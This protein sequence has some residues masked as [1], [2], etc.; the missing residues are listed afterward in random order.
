MR[1][2]LLYAFTLLSFSLSAQVVLEKDIN[3][4][5][6]GSWP[7]AFAEYDGYL[8]FKADDGTH[9]EELHR[10]HLATGAEELVANVRPNEDGAGISRVLAFDGKIYF[11]ARDGIG[12]RPYLYVYNPADNT[13][14]RLSD[15]NNDQV[16]DPAN[17]F[18][19]DGVLYFASEFIDPSIGVEFGSYDPATNLI[20]RLAD[21]QEGDGDSYPNF[22]NEVDGKIY[23]IANDGVSTSRLWRYDPA[24]GMTE[25]MAYETPGGV[26]PGNM[27]ILFAFNDQLFFRGTVTGQGTELWI[28]D[29]ATNSLVDF[30]EVYPGAGSSAPSGFT[31]FDER[32]FFGA[33]TVGGGRELRVYDPMTNEVTMV[34]DIHPDDD[35][36]PGDMF[37]LDGKLYFTANIDDV[38]RRLFSYDPVTDMVEEEVSQP[39]GDDS[40]FLSAL[41]AADGRIFLTGKNP[42]TA[43]ELYSY[44]PGNTEVELE[45]DINQNTI[46]SSPFEF[47]EYNGRLYFGA[48]EVNSGREIWVYDPATGNT[49]ILSDAEG[50]MNPGGFTVLG[51]RLY[52]E[53]VH[54]TEGYGLLYYDD[55]TGNITATSFLTPTTI[56]H[57]SELTAYDGK[58]YLNAD[59][60]DYGTELFVY[61]PDTDMLEL[62]AEINVNGDGRPEWLYVFN[63]ILYFEADDGN[64]GTE[65]WQ[66][67]AS[68]G[69]VSQIAD[70]NAGPEGS[71]PEWLVGY[72][73]ELYFSAFEPDESNELYSYNP[74]TGEVTRRTE[75]NGNLSPD[76]LTVYRDK[77]FFNGRFSAQ[78]NAELCYY[79]PALDTLVLTEDLNPSASN[80]SYLTVFDDKLYFG[81]FTDEYGRELWQYND[82]TLSIVADIWTGEPDSDPIYITNFND[83]LYFN[84]DDGTRGSE[85]WSLASCLNVFVDTEPQIDGEPGSIDLTVE[86][87][88]PPYIIS[89]STGDDSE[90]LINLEAGEYSVTVADAS[91]CLSEL[92]AEVSFV[93]NTRELLDENLVTL[94][95]NPNR[96][97]FQLLLDEQLVVETVEVFDLAGHL[98]YQQLL[99]AQAPSIEV[100]LQYAPAGIYVVMIR[101]AEGV[102]QKRVLVDR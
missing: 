81:V 98:I 5:P 22:F 46:G 64:D 91:G 96:G 33:R 76:Y 28:Y 95:P 29:I 88:L 71:N 86:G 10:F 63:D 8:Y 89:W 59:L 25:N 45:A 1:T 99:R 38:E 101:T 2:S 17:L 90:D 54:P 84:A 79:D 16:R 37:E 61:D 92:T 20:T 74:L 78:S 87:G 102:I 13:T 66:F 19:F 69:E 52:F 93:S 27:N 94:A 12:S 48:D 55:A 40:N 42:Q 49:E 11:D 9:G 97:T 58:L 100:H 75:V 85:I 23:F 83:K 72:G 53:G 7:G 6:A 39:N 30:P 3:Q 77:I 4:D 43:R 26:D 73:D 36:N 31:I 50:S 34:A 21:I 35:G 24:T 57:I 56:G 51:D 44:T 62:A 65:L 15:M 68:T 70:I 41:A 60:D 47:T 67:D 14:Q 18:A 80:P 32:L 82:T